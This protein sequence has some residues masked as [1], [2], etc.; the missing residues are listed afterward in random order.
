M[1]HEDSLPLC[2]QDFWKIHLSWTPS[3][4]RTVSQG[5]LLSNVLSSPRPAFG[6]SLITVF[7]IPLLTSPRIQSSLISWSLS[8][9]QLLTCIGYKELRESCSTLL[10]FPWDKRKL[11]GLLNQFSVRRR[12]DLDPFPSCQCCWSCEFVVCCW[13]FLIEEL[14]SKGGHG[15]RGEMISKWWCGNNYV[16]GCKIWVKEK[17]LN[18]QWDLYVAFL[19]SEP[20]HF[21]VKQAVLLPDSGD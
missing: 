20:H 21:L 8:P 15:A 6:N 2:L 16:R 1:A 12:N 5:T 19:S 11:N 14:R 18:L 7:L 3:P 4:L 13:I 17:P 10:P 9:C